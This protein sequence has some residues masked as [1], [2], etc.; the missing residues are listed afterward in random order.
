MQSLE[1][2]RLLDFGTALAG[3]QVGQLLADLGMEVIKIETRVKPDG[4]RL[5][6]PI[7]GDDI[8]GGDDGKWLDMQPMFHVT[9]RNKLSFTINL[10]QPGAMDVFKRLVKISD[11][12]LDN[13]SPGVMARLGLDQAELQKIKSD[14]IS[15][16]LTGCGEFGPMRDTL[17]YA[18]LIIALGGLESLLGYYGDKIPMNL[19]PGYGD[20]N[21]SMHGAFA[22]LAALW[23][24]E[25]TG[26]GQH[27]S[28]AESYAVTN[29]LGEAIM[30]YKMNGRV[31]GLQGNRHPTLC[32]HGN[33]PCQGDDKWVSI[34]VDTEEEW[35]NLCTGLGAP[36]WIADKRFADKNARRQHWEELDKLI[37]AKTAQHGAYDITDILQKVNVAATPVMNCED[38]FSDP[39]FREREVNVE[40]QHP[41]IGTEYVYNNPMRLADMPPTIR[42]PAPSIGENNDY[43]L[44]DLL[45]YSQQEVA[46]MVERKIIF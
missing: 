41:I 19:A 29:L 7:V 36:E 17:V 45:G 35:K 20:T 24:R 5:G 26:E 39:H 40:I 22:V 30:D 31:Q 42:R 25:Q 44:K 23:H 32:P 1:G 38:Q 4:L 46:A 3:P 28:L 6:R 8:A 37:A 18:P 12:V 9:N 2:Y 16:T 13:S 21:A 15:I 27:V 34:A 43:V 33:Y 14:I 10:K 11:V